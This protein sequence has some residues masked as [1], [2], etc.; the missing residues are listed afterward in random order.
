MRTFL[1]ISFIIFFSGHAFSQSSTQSKSLMDKA[2]ALYEASNGVKLSFK[3]TLIDKDGTSFAPQSGTAFLK[4][5]Q[6]KLEMESMDIWFDGTTQW[7][8]LKDVNEVNIST[9]TGKEVA[10]VSPIALLGMYKTGFVLKSPS[11]TTIN[12][13]SAY[14][15]E[16]SPVS[17]NGDFQSITAVIEKESGHIIHATVVMTNG[18]KNL[19]D[20]SDYNTNHQFNNALFKFDKSK[21]PNAEVV[22]L[23]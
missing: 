4:G 15:I 20:I 12:G 21:H 22:D 2:Y 23:R 19:I 6:F 5:N 16:M 3:S 14:K 9:P 1:L 8:W 18:M 13:K 11:P 17:R 7:V 10:S